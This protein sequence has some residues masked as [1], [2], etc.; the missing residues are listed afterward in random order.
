[1]LSQCNW[2]LEAETCTQRFQIQ[3]DVLSEFAESC[4]PQGERR[5][6]YGPTSSMDRKSTAE[7]SMTRPM[8]ECGPASLKPLPFVVIRSQPSLVMLLLLQGLLVEELH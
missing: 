6:P 8:Q 7:K 2:K 4:T 1:M 5:F 3:F